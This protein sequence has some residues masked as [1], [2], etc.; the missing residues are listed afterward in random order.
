M[1]NTTFP[2][3][4]TPS[5][6]LENLA[7]S[8]CLDRLTKRCACGPWGWERKSSAGTCTLWTPLPSHQMQVGSSRRRMTRLCACG[9]FSRERWL[10][11]ALSP[12]LITNLMVQTRST[13]LQQGFATPQT[14]LKGRGI[15]VERCKRMREKKNYARQHLC[16]SPSHSE[17]EIKKEDTEKWKREIIK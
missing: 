9:R 13:R 7:C 2:P 12:L 14:F 6:S 10:S 11:R 1:A 17:R 4:R 5:E 8:S 3:G 16:L 15:G